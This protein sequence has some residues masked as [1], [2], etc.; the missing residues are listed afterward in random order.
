VTDPHHPRSPIERGAEVVVPPPLGLTGCDTHPHRQL[1]RHLRFGR[2]IDSGPRR[3]EGRDYAIT[4]V[5]EELAVVGFDRVPKHRVVSSQ[6][7]P[8]ELG[9]ALPPRRGPFDVGEEEGHH[10]TGL[11][12]HPIMPH[13]SSS[14]PGRADARLCR[15]RV[16]SGRGGRSA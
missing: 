4:G 14:Q 13:R 15:R 2:G 7:R 3:R 10:A 11:N 1:E 5:L 6:G 16:R 8:H 9:V 12:H